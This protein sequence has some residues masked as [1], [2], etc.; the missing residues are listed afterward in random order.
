MY[1]KRGRG[2]FRSAN[3][4]KKPFTKRRSSPSDDE[5]TPAPK[6]AKKDADDELFVPTLD[7]DDDK[8]PFVAVRHSLPV[9]HVRKEGAQD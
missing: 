6:K 2:G 9:A 5:S 4:T 3:T 7:I 8:N 1:A